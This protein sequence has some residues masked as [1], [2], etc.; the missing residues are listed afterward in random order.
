MKSTSNV[1]VR[2]APS[3]TGNLHI[4]T[5][6]TT[7]INYLFAKQHGGKYILRF[8]DT[9]KARST[10]EFEDNI[11]DGLKWLGLEHDE[12]Y[13]SSE[14]NDIYISYVEKMLEN[15]FAYE[16]EESELNKDEKVI[17]FKNPNKKVVFEDLIRGTIEVDTTD[18]G[19]FVI[20]RS[21]NDPL[22]HFAVVVDDHEMGITHVIRGEDHISN[23]PRQILIQEGIGATR[24]LYA[25]LPLIVD[26]E[27][28]KLSKR[29][30][31]EAVWLDTY[32]KEG[33]LKDAILNFLALMG[34]NPGTEQEIF[35]LD[36]LIETFSIE[37]VQKGAAVFNIEKLRWVNKEHIKRLPWE[38]SKKIIS[39][40]IRERFGDVEVSDGLAEVVKER[41]ETFG[42]IDKLLG[43]GELDYFYR[44]PE[45]NLEKISWKTDDANATKGHL[46]K[47]RDLVETEG[48]VMAYAEEVGKGSVLW[49]LRYALSGKEK[50]PDPFTLLKILGK[51]KSL[52]RIDK[53]VSLL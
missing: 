35:S 41:I 14:R 23:T 10:K 37:R 15:G 45:L 22:Y 20:A 19:D 40:K 1:V 33:Y 48:D 43:E 7:L 49:P 27:R 12:M 17:R 47:V 39:D 2:M 42:D 3:P 38:D 53:A 5:A 8:E 26:I 30:H 24:P 11:I 13:R 51:D 28:Q 32:K 44:E 18:L 4:G 50:S 9:D 25:H 36:E 46:L 31:G 16:A 6:R 34:W 52:E 21:K 29:K